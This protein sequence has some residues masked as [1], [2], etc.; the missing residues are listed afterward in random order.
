MSDIVLWYDTVD[1]G[2]L[3]NNLKDSNY[4]F[5]NCTAILPNL[6][7]KNNIDFVLSATS[8]G[9]EYFYKKYINLKSF[10]PIE[11]GHYNSKEDTSQFPITKF[12]FFKKTNKGTEILLW[13][14][15]EGFKFT[16]KNDSIN[17]LIELIHKTYPDNPIRFVFG[18]F[19]RPNNIPN[20]VN[21]KCFKNFFWYDTIVNI[22][23]PI[24]KIDKQAPYDFIT[25]NR[26]FRISRCMVLDDLKNSG[27]LDNAFYTNMMLGYQ[28]PVFLL[29]Q[30]KK[31]YTVPE[32]ELFCKMFQPT[33][34]PNIDADKL[35][36]VDIKLTDL[37][38]TDIS[39]LEIINET[40]FDS[41]DNLFIT[42]KTYRSIAMGHIFLICG[43][44]GTLSHLK[45][46]GFQTFDDLFD[47]SYDQY[48]SFSQRWHIIKQNIKLWISM[49]AREKKSYYIKSY[50]KLLHNQKLLYDRNFKEEI[51]ELF[52]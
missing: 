34:L 26:R 8:Y 24:L 45:Q 47:E 5:S 43:Q 14:P 38:L 23:K 42:E 21:Y 40:C 49:S 29:E 44:K 22:T 15:N 27:M 25:L 48:A 20:Y 6:L 28:D 12:W 50:D 2:I 33:S 51:T 19:H 31:Y 10:Y 13:Y 1:N 4:S 11:I 52:Q 35:S 41:A 30:F 17:E 16:R 18:D 3:K 46:E 7:I 36:T 9:K 32:D 37:N 39:Y